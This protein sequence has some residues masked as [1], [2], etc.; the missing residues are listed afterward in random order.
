[1]L[2][3]SFDFAM[4]EG[5]LKLYEYNVDSAGCYPEAGQILGQWAAAHGVT[6]G[7]DAGQN[8]LVDLTEA[9]GR[10][11][12]GGIVHILQDTET[13]ETYM[14]EF[15]RGAIEASGSESRIIKGLNKGMRW[16]DTGAIQDAQGLAVKTVWKTWAWET[17]IDQMRE[18]EEEEQKIGRAHV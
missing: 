10:I 6:Q 1:M 12:S 11:D 17:A 13:E 15:M 3:R 9:W 18:R 7:E 8:I 2:F 16:D 4:T 5:G 14:A